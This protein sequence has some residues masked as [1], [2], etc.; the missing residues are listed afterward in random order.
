MYVWLCDA[1]VVTFRRYDVKLFFSKTSQLSCIISI[2]I[3]YL[4]IFVANFKPY[5]YTIFHLHYVI[6]LTEIQ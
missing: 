2:Y 5:K 1:A 6:I 3:K 4:S